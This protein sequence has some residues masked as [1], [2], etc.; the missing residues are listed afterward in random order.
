MALWTQKG[1]NMERKW[2]SMQKGGRG[3]E[4]VDQLF[5]DIPT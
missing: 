1:A 2:E 4:R 5:I 3:K